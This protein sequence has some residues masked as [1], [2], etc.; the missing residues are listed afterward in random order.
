ME[1]VITQPY[2]KYPDIPMDGMPE[3]FPCVLTMLISPR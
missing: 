3:Y 1:R 2:K